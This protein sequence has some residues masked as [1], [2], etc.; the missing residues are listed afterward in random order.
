MLIPAPSL[1]PV[2]AGVTLRV[3]RDELDL[4][5]QALGAETLANLGPKRFRAAQALYQ[6]LDTVREQRRARQRSAA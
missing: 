2:D 1:A 4:L 5:R 3:S 6:R